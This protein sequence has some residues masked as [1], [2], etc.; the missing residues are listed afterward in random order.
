LQALRK[1]RAV[2]KWLDFEY[3]GE[4]WNVFIATTSDDPDIGETQLAHCDYEKRRILIWEG[5]RSQARPTI[6][7]HELL[8][9]VISPQESSFQ[10]ILKARRKSN[11]EREEAMIQLLA[12]PLA[13][14]LRSCGVLKIP[15]FPA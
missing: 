11:V 10:S 4:K 5:L 14:I 6:L 12:A 8:H 2:K 9:A 7:I 13:S 1:A 15:R 3:F